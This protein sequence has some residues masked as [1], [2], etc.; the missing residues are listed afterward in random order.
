MTTKVKS[1]IKKRVREHNRKMRKEARK[2]QA[3]GIKTGPKSQKTLHVPNLYPYKKKLIQ[4][5]ENSK[6]TENRKRMLE[7][8]QL[9]SKATSNLSVVK[10]DPA[11]RERQFMQEEGLKNKSK[12]HSTY[13][14]KI[15]VR[16]NQNANILKRSRKDPRSIT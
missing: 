8:M 9:K 3:L 10:E 2:L 13:N 16:W 15:F 7:K 4:H 6:L 14:H 11:E 1:R 5:I 12:S